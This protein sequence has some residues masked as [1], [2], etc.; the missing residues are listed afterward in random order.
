MS[1]VFS[2]RELLGAA[3]TSPWTKDFRHL[4]SFP[5]H[6]LKRSN[7]RGDPVLKSVRPADRIKYWNIVPGD[8]IRVLG[9]KT[10][11]LREVLSINRI[12]NR[13]FVR[14]TPNV[15]SSSVSFCAVSGTLGIL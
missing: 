5:R 1:A 4:K 13:V 10:R 6:W 3:T 8:Q 2:R 14:G 7:I 12:S 15:S 9:D 11:T